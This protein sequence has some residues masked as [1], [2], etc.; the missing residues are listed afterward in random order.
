MKHWACQIPLNKRLRAFLKFRLKGEA[1]IGTR[2][3]NRGGHLSRNYYWTFTDPAVVKV[4]IK[5]GFLASLLFRKVGEEQN[6]FERG[7]CLLKC[8][9]G[10]T[11]I[12]GRALFNACTLIQRNYV[13]HKCATWQVKF[14]T[15]M[16]P[17]TIRTL[18]FLSIYQRNNSTMTLGKHWKKQNRTKTKTFLNY[19]PKR[20]DLHNFS[21]RLRKMWNGIIT[22]KLTYESKIRQKD[23]CRLKNN[24]YKNRHMYRGK[25]KT[26]K[27]W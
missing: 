27:E 10:W 22:I 1:L 15:N 6:H 18:Y 12:R 3:L 20:C 17:L 23:F 25:Q 13:Q 11:L 21:L 26:V 2:A 9:D 19:N 16:S 7:S 4:G 24:K 14:T 5:T 8:P